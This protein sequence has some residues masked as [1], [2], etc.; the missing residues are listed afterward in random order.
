MKNH[1][2]LDLVALAQQI[3]VWGAELGLQGVGIT[4]CDLGAAE[5]NLLDWLARGLHGEMD[6]MAKHGTKRTHPAELVPGTVRIISVRI[7]YLPPDA[8]DSWEVMASPELAYISRYA[9][10]QHSGNH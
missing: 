2:Q 3:K 8:A 1:D 10:A 6:Y 7:D 5:A 4:D 9:L